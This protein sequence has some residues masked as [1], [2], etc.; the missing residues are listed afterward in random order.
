MFKTVF[1]IPRQATASES[2][3]CSCF[4]VHKGLPT[5]MES[6]TGF[7]VDRHKAETKHSS[8]CCW[9]VFYAMRYCLINRSSAV[10]WLKA[11]I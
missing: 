2:F 11:K 5:C 10:P 3:A 1:Q 7:L 4:D 9:E 8:I 6:E